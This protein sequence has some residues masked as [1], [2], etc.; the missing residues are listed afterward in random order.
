MESVLLFLFGIVFIVVGIGVSIGL[1]ELGHLTAAKIFGVK[2]TQYMIGFGNTLWS[3]T[4]GDTEYGVKSLP[5]GGYIA[6]IGMFPPGPDGKQPRR[7]RLAQ[8]IDSA[9]QSSA[10]TVPAGEEH[11][12]FYAAAPWKRIIIM[13]AGPFAN[14]VIAVVV[15]GIIA[16]GVGIPSS[17]PVVDSVS[18]CLKPATSTSTTCTGADPVAPA[19]L[20]G[21]QPGDRIVS[22][23]GHRIGND[24]QKASDLIGDAPGRQISVVVERGGQ[25]VTL[26]MTPVLSSKTVYDAQGNA[27]VVKAGVVGF[28]FGQG[29]VR[30]PISSVP[31][32]VGKQLSA[33]TGVF[34]NLPNRMVQVWNAAFGSQQRDA[35]GPVGLIGV[36][37]LA[38]DV[39][40][41]TQTPFVDRLEWLLSIVAALNISLFVFNLVPLLPLDG[42]HILGALWEQGKR[43][44]FAA[45]RR[46]KKPKHVDMARLLPLTFGVV[47]VLIAME[48]LLAYA[49]LVKPI[50]AG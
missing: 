38:G 20:A 23:D 31:G 2:V 14:L 32:A 12:A 11:R 45:F 30:Q 8:F 36:G 47:T 21:M 26:S 15:I 9:R 29:N 17:I 1:H 6:M 34:L 40:S 49:D 10:E 27:K 46:G 3:R 35:N 50:S 16:V 48:L 42:G 5:I 28:A 44:W 18:Q 43:W 13:F 22:V 39:A 33:T 24:F 25:D 19:A 41:N 4:K 37:R 7:G